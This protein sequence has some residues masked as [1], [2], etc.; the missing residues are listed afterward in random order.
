MSAVSQKKSILSTILSMYKCRRCHG[1]KTKY[2]FGGTVMRNNKQL[3]KLLV[4]N[5]WGDEGEGVPW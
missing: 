1:H 5:A 4:G 3:L 2:F